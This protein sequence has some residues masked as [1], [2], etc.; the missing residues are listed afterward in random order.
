MHSKSKY[1]F[2]NIL[3]TGAQSYT[4]VPGYVYI[5]QLLNSTINITITNSTVWL[6]LKPLCLRGAT[7]GY[8]IDTR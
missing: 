6:W 5:Q 3:E 1:F 8:I 4:Y 2:R 7:A